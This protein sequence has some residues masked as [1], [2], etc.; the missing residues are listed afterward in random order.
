MDISETLAPSS[1]QLDAVDLSASGP[2]TFTVQDV[3]KGSAEQPVNVKLADFP[4]V[5]RPS[6]SMRRILG[7]LWGTDA[8][9][10]RGKRLTLFCDDTVMFGGEA[11]GG[12]RISHMSDIKGVQTVPLIVTRGRSKGYKVQP[13]TEPAPNPGPTLEDVKA[14]DDLAVLKAMW[15]QSGPTLRQAIETRVAEIKAA[16][17]AKPADE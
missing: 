10:W 8:S 16:T 12:I 4:R 3:S 17:E 1:D 15:Q 5:W 14:C 7:K 9:T 11:V 6:K 2:R 13:L